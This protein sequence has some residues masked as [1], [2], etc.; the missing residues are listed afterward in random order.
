MGR[1]IPGLTSA[2]VLGTNDMEIG[3]AIAEIITAISTIT[4]IIETTTRA[5]GTMVSA[6]DIFI[7]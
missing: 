5:G 1:L 2:G 6:A 3:S 7:R 4:G